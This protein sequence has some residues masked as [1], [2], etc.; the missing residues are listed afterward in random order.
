[1]FSAFRIELLGSAKK[2]CDTHTD[3]PSSDFSFLWF[4]QRMNS[5]GIHH[6]AEK[7]TKFIT[8]INVKLFMLHK[9]RS[10]TNSCCNFQSH[11]AKWEDELLI[12]LWN[13][14]YVEFKKWKKLEGI[15]RCVYMSLTEEIIFLWHCL[16]SEAPS[17]Q[18]SRTW[19]KADAI[20]QL[21]KRC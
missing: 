17:A 13:H 14:V 3:L 16:M 19:K 20:K 15:F 2:D 6:S 11:A 1:M 12:L 21:W 5:K 10:P 8:C 4:S 9:T 18:C 7:M